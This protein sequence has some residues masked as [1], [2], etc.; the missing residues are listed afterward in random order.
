M[1][2]RRHTGRFTEFSSEGLTS[3]CEEGS[4]AAFAVRIRSKYVADLNSRDSETECGD[5]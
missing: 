3:D 5:W 4:F 1:E 2:M